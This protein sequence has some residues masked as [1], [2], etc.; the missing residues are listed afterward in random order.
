MALILIVETELSLLRDTCTPVVPASRVFPLAFALRGSGP[1][2]GDPKGKK[3]ITQNHGGG[4]VF[5]ALLVGHSSI[6]DRR[7]KV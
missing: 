4:V 2:K 6:S 3:R 1:P 5:L 7:S